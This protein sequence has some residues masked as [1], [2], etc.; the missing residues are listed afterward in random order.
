VPHL[1]LVNTVFHVRYML[2]PQSTLHVRLQQ[3][4]L[5]S[6]LSTG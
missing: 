6:L 4:S 3:E 2:E 1:R 5:I